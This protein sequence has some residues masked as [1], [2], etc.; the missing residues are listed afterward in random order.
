MEEKPGMYQQSDQTS[1]VVPPNDSMAPPGPS[2]KGS[3]PMKHVTEPSVPNLP[4][5]GKR[6]ADSNNPSSSEKRYVFKTT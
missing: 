2:N 3:S 6:R 5:P 1:Q 4:T